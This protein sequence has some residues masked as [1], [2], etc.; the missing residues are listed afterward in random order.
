MLLLY[1]ASHYVK[2]I[3]S[4]DLAVAQDFREK[5]GTQRLPRVNG[6]NSGATVR[7]P[8][9]LV[10]ATPSDNFEAQ[11]IQSCNELLAGETRQPRHL[12]ESKPLNSDELQILRVFALGLQAELGGLSNANHQLIERPRLGV[13]SLELRDRSNVETLTVALDDDVKFSLHDA[14]RFY[15][16]NGSNLFRRSGARRKV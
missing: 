3:V 6:H 1:A 11:N 14:M 8:Q 2:E 12:N 4:A 7:V 10:A 13:A 15:R 9:K 16:E 5:P